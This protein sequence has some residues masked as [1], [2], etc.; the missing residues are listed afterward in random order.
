MAVLAS[1]KVIKK[2]KKSSGDK[3]DVYR[4]FLSNTGVLD[5]WLPFYP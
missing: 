5:H 4:K 2:L 1:V 3:I